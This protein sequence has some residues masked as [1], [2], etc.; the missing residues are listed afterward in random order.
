MA[1]QAI[2][3]HGR[4]DSVGRA[5]VALDGFSPGWK[6]LTSVRA[7]DD[8]ICPLDDGIQPARPDFAFFNVVFL[9]RG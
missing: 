8:W 7:P 6:T 3:R 2:L 5:F 4:R 1:F 9:T